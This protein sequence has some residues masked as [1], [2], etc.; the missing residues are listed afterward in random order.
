MVPK[1]TTPLPGRPSYAPA[2]REGKEPN[3]PMKQEEMKRILEIGVQLSAERDL[4]RLLE[5]LLSCVMELAH[6]DAGTLY[7]RDGDALRFKIMYNHTMHT[8]AGGDG[9]DPDL[10]PVALRRENVCALSLL[11]D[12]TIRIEDVRHCVDY[13]FS[14]P[15]EYD[16]RTGYYTK[17]MLVVPMRNRNGEGLGVIQLINALNE[18]GKIISFAEDM[19][20]VLES[21]AS[22]AAIT[23]QNVRYIEEIKEQFRAFVRALSSAVDARSAY[24]GSHTRHMAACGERF[25]DYLNNRAEEA[26]EEP[27]FTPAQKEEFL[28]SVWLH[29]I[30]KLT[31]PREVMDKEERLL[32]IQKANFTHRMEAVRLRAE[33]DCLSGRIS[34]QERESLKEQTRTALADVNRICKGAPLKEQDLSAIEQLAGRTYIGEDGEEHP[35]LEEEEAAMLRIPRGTLSSKEREIMEKHV[36]VTDTILSELHF[37]EE[38]SHVRQWAAS[39]HELLSG[40]GYPKHLSGDQIPRE[41]RMITILDIFDAMVADDRPYKPGMPVGKALGI[42]A[43]RAK[44]GD[45]DSRLVELFAESECWKGIVKDKEA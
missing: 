40:K 12:R 33:I 25:I 19:T 31:T 37:S 26:G 29:D 13:D 44:D 7:L 23:I 11:E 1:K 32:P 4:N 36:V 30:G 41:V 17:S 43:A 20:L 14:G 2:I 10:P 9:Q 5:E 38:L 28:M 35:W 22:Q 15:I 3:K 27:W 39:H 34:G 21:I 18:D 45:L 8:Y 42:L 16:R 24:N 6:C